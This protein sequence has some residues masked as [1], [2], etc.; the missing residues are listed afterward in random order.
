MGG[1]VVPPDP[2][3]L[4]WGQ[5]ATRFSPESLRILDP[6]FFALPC[7][8][9][10]PPSPSSKRSQRPPSNHTRPRPLPGAQG[11]PED[12]EP[13]AN[14]KCRGKVRYLPPVASTEGGGG[15]GC[16]GSF[17]KT[18][19]RKNNSFETKNMFQKQ[20][21]NTRAPRRGGYFAFISTHPTTPILHLKK[22]ALHP[23]MGK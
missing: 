17:E 19:Y 14:L 7:G 9:W 20:K 13:L 8:C 12:R 15:V 3:E 21:I 23:T 18:R 10:P 6:Y 1:W 4:L 5:C 11:L 22:R 16:S 2:S